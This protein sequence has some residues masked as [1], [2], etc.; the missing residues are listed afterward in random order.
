[1]FGKQH[2]SFKSVSLIITATAFLNVSPALFAAG[3]CPDDYTS[4]LTEYDCFLNIT[5]IF[6][7]RWVNKS[8]LSSDTTLT[9]GG[10]ESSTGEN[11]AG[12]LYHTQKASCDYLCNPSY[13]CYGYTPYCEID[14][15]CGG[16]RPYFLAS[17]SGTLF[18]PVICP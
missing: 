18:F 16:E 15:G 4:N 7:L 9:V 14:P 3:T 2:F 6:E 11:G 8:G 10:C 13:H 12:I 1:M 5:D 17:L